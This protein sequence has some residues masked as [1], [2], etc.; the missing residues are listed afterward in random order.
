[1]A[2][3]RSQANSLRSTGP[4]F[5]GDTDDALT[6]AILDGA[7]DT[8]A[9]DALDSV[10][11]PSTRTYAPNDTEHLYANTTK[12]VVPGAHPSHLSHGVSPFRRT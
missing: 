9:F 4:Q 11:G 3:D 8:Y 1:M 5:A 6:E 2:W 7:L 10:V 12:P